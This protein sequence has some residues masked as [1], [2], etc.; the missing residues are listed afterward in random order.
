MKGII[1]NQDADSLLYGVGRNGCTLTEEEMRNYASQFKGSHMTDIM[2]ALCN[3][4]ASFPSQVI[5]DLVAKY[6]QKRENGI[7]VDYT[8]NFITMSAC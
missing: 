5:T 6:H 8:D 4:C 1:Y 2:L 7:D 3:S